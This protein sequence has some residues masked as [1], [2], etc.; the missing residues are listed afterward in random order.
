MA[1]WELE[2]HN[3]N[4][5]YFQHS[6]EL[7]VKRSGGDLLRLFTQKQCQQVQRWRRPFYW[8]E[9]FLCVQAD[10]N[11][12]CTRGAVSRDSQE[13]RAASKC[14][15]KTNVAW[16]SNSSWQMA[17]NQIVCVCS[18]TAPHGAN[19]IKL[20]PHPSIWENGELGLKK[21]KK[22]TVVCLPPFL[23]LVVIEVVSLRHN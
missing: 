7:A 14:T 16:S 22:K 21:K 18:L 19:V 20:R 12:N 15:N 8:N 17:L 3:F 11:A 5:R 13:T 1:P 9:V 4:P 23:R 6:A 2:K 10:K